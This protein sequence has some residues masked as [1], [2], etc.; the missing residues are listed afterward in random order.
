MRSVPYS[1]PSGHAHVC[2]QAD[3]DARR[4]PGKSWWDV[5]THYGDAQEFPP[6]LTTYIRLL[7]MHEE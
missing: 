1:T 3:V 5:M 4:Q 7:K 6:E 2:S